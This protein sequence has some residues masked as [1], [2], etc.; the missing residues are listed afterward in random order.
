MIVRLFE[1]VYERRD[2]NSCQRW[3]ELLSLCQRLRRN[4]SFPT[5]TRYQRGSL[6][7]TSN[8]AIKDWPE[9][10][11]GDEIITAAI[12][13]RLLHSCHVLNIRGR[14]YR[15]RE[16]EESLNGRS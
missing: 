10:L 12:L 13:D 8:K 1:Q 4:R 7:I 2:L 16:L 6:C 14:S 11:A 5:E 3:I 9:M 15:L